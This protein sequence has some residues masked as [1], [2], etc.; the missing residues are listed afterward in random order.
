MLTDLTRKSPD[1]FDPRKDAV[2]SARIKEGEVTAVADQRP[3]NAQWHDLSLPDLQRHART[4]HLD[5]VKAHSSVFR[6]KF[7]ELRGRLWGWRQKEMS[8]LLADPSPKGERFRETISSLAASEVRAAVRG[9]IHDSSKA[10]PLPHELFDQLLLQGVV[11][12][13]SADQINI[14]Q[15]LEEKNPKQL[16]RAAEIIWRYSGIE[17]LAGD[18]A[19]SDVEGPPDA[20]LLEYH[21]SPSRQG[22]D[23]KSRVAWSNE[24][25]SALVTKTPII[26]SNMEANS[27]LVS[28][29]LARKAGVM[30]ALFSCAPEDRLQA[31]RNFG[32]DILITVRTSDDEMKLAKQILDAGGNV[33]IEMAN[34]HNHVG[35]ACVTELKEYIRQQNYSSP[36][37]VT[38]GKS[39]GGAFVIAAIMAGAD[40][41]FV[42]R[43][44]SMICSTPTVTGLGIRTWSAIWEAAIAQR[45]A[46]ILTGRDVPVSGDA[47]ISS[48]ADITKLMLAGAEGGMVGTTFIRTIDSPPKKY[49]I[50]LP[51]E[52]TEWRTESWGDASEK[53]K[54]RERERKLKM[55]LPVTDLAAVAAQGVE[56]TQSIPTNRAGDPVTIEDVAKRIALELQGAIG[57]LNAQSASE[58]PVERRGGVFRFPEEGALLELKAKRKPLPQGKVKEER[59]SR[60]G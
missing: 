4:P 51:D 1:I 41:V 21:G 26:M 15:L 29:E 30:P 24:Y 58:L 34:A 31:A 9:L 39:V 46:F 22:I 33:H 36:R 25:S 20:S 60:I 19:Y 47:G 12:I 45:I 23:V 28:S 3:E 5:V 43:G 32:K 48:G 13:P 17:G 14:Q 38:I 37:F 7:P 6:A 27:D 59:A 50:E 8:E 10:L 55:G 35:L 54:E 11:R 2:A 44:S 49:R 40:G 42:N 56:T 53:A 16:L 57:D 18:H 52:S